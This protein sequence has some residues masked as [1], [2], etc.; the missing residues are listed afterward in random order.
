MTRYAAQ[1]L[2]LQE[3]VGSLSV[4]KAADFA[5]WSIQRPADLAYAIGGNPCV[6]SVFAGVPRI[7]QAVTLDGVAANRSV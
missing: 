2:G 5:L 4:G 6:A 3:Q 1:A 7:S